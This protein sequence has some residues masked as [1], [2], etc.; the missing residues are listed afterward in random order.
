MLGN[1]SLLIQMKPSERFIQETINNN[2]Y[3][4]DFF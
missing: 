4:K 3:E 1:S 2:Y